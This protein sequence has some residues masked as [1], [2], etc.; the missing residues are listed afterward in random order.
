MILEN[1]CFGYEN[2]FIINNLSYTF[3]KNHNYLILGENG[4][5]KTTLIKIIL[6]FIKLMKG[7]ITFE[8]D[9]IFSYCPDHNGLYE[10]LSV[11]DN[12]MFRLAIYKQDY[13]DYSERINELLQ[14]YSLF[15]S[16]DKK[17]SELSHGMKKKTALIATF[18][19]DCN[20]LFLDEPTNGID[21]ESKEEIIKMIN[22]LTN[23]DRTIICITHDTDLKVSLR[24]TSLL[25]EKGKLNEI[26]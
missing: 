26:I 24:A 12:T 16:K 10:D 19:I 5:G 13:N 11:M 9:S 7:N 6:G 20:Y 23:N 4:A 8:K 18:I 21:D 14:K 2:N 3:E 25:L 15:D 1:T 17:V 22:D